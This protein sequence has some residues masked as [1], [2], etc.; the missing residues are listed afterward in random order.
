MGR[1]APLSRAGGGLAWG[2]EPISGSSANKRSLWHLDVGKA[3][4]FT[5]PTLSHW[6]RE[7]LSRSLWR[8]PG[9]LNSGVQR[10]WVLPCGTHPSDF[11][12]VSLERGGS[13]V[14]GPTSYACG[15]RRAIH[16]APGS[17]LQ[18]LGTRRECGQRVFD[19]LPAGLPRLVWFR[20]TSNPVKPRMAARGRNPSR[21]ES[22][23][24]LQ[25][26][27]Q[28][29]LLRASGA[30]DTGS[31]TLGP[32]ERDGSRGRGARAA[33]RAAQ[34]PKRG[35]LGP[36]P[37]GPGRAGLQEEHS[38]KLL[39]SREENQLCTRRQPHWAASPWAWGWPSSPWVPT[40]SCLGV[41]LSA[42]PSPF[43]QG[44]WSLV[45]SLELDRF[46]K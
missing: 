7:A 2:L 34:N 19:H 5:R 21:A 8:R 20:S 43:P 36:R 14:W 29:I 40:W 27:K 1:G 30:S 23:A 22:L 3:E 38:R 15:C 25:Q 6:D 24:S 18:P 13:G 17:R 42:P 9:R 45:T 26:R 39:H 46:C 28:Q 4:V 11:D 32:Q 33:F 35:S 41:R 12:S 37:P 16:S 44:R 10:A 31:H